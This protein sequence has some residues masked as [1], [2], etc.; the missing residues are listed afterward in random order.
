MNNLGNNIS[1]LRKQ[2]GYSQEDLATRINVTRQAVSKWEN[3]EAVPDLPNLIELSNIFKTKIDDLVN[4]EIESRQ[5]NIYPYSLF[6][7]T[8]RE[9]KILMI[10]FS[11]IFIA[12]LIFFLYRSGIIG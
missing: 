1:R 4:N 2:A 11:L 7:R 12:G 3:G 5:P 10:V 9:W 8:K 6:A